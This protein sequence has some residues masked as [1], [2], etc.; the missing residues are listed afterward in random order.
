MFGL[1]VLTTAV[2]GVR[3]VI[4]MVIGMDIDQ[5]IITAIIVGI[6]RDIMLEAGIIILLITTTVIYIA[7]DLPVLQQHN[8]NTEIPILQTG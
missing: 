4:I 2:C 7:A 8:P 3:V 1:E 6:R 5:G